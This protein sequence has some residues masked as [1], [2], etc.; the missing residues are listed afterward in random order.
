M[1][2]FIVETK[3]SPLFLEKRY[4]EQFVITTISVTTPL[5]AAK[6]ST[7]DKEMISTYRSDANYRK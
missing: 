4:Y 1:K 3:K 6:V 2:M 7:P 5:D